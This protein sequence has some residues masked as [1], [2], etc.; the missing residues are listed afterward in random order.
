MTSSSSL[1]WLI[2]KLRLQNCILWTNP[3]S[4]PRL[5]IVWVW[6]DVLVFV[7][8]FLI[9]KDVSVILQIVYTY[10]YTIAPFFHSYRLHC[11]WNPEIVGCWVDTITFNQQ[12]LDI[13]NF[14]S[15]FFLVILSVFQCIRV[16]LNA[17]KH[18]STDHLINRRKCVWHLGH[19]CLICI[20]I[21]IF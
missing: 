9:L 17:C 6:K 16:K 4:F 14:L 1:I 13:N 10:V 20:D 19:I 21:A 3:S 2:Y 18:F 7:P 5:G 11:V 8:T 15:L 12:Q